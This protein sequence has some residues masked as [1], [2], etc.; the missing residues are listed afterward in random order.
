MGE[1]PRLL[2]LEQ[3]HLVRVGVR[4]RLGLGLGSGLG[5]GL[6]L[7]SGSGLGSGLGRVGLEQRHWLGEGVGG[8]GRSRGRVR[9]RVR[10]RLGLEVRHLLEERGQ[11][12]TMTILTMTLPTMPHLL[13]ERGQLRLVGARLLHLRRGREGGGG[14]VGEGRW[15]RRW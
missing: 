2:G 3:R 13:E 10:G 9:G 12:L 7:G 1:A 14:K 15:R 11:L 8:R 5:S 4:V 6:G